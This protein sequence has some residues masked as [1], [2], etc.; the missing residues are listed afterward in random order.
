MEKIYVKPLQ[1]FFILMLFDEPPFLHTYQELL[2]RQIEEYFVL[3]ENVN[4]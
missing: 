3:I 2:L 4:F 1:Q